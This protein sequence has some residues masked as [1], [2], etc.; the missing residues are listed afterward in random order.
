MKK[1]E[2]KHTKYSKKTKNKVS[3]DKRKQKLMIRGRWKSSKLMAVTTD[4]KHTR[5]VLK[6]VLPEPH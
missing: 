2:K 1:R 4:W 5:N 3:N 6:V